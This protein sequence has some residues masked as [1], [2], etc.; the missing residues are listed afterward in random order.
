[1]HKLKHFEYVDAFVEG[2]NEKFPDY[3]FTTVMGKKYTKVVRQHTKF[4]DATKAQRSVFCFLDADNNV[5]KPAAWTR[6]AKGVRYNL[7]DNVEAVV[8][9]ADPYGSWLYAH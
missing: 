2:L 7:T 6:P 4:E 5:Y 9:Q 8:A 3:T 1:M